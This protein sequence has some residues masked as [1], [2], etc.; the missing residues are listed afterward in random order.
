LNL[1]LVHPPLIV[2][3]VDSA[4]AARVLQTHDIAILEPD[5][6]QLLPP[7]ADIAV[8]AEM[9]TPQTISLHRWEANGDHLR[10]GSLQAEFVTAVHL[11]R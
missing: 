6:F 9:Q 7:A 1:D 10:P 4:S 5:G 8:S 3:H 11:L 2:H